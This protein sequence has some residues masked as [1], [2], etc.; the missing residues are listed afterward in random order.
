MA[1]AAAHRHH[2][3]KVDDEEHRAPPFDAEAP[4]HVEQQVH[5]CREEGAG[6]TDICQLLF[7]TLVGRNAEEKKSRSQPASHGLS[8][9]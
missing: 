7:G 3:G 8:A 1:V 5:H 4:A 2:V 9:S 6:R